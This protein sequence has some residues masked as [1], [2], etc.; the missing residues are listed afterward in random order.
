MWTN[1]SLVDAW[2]AAMFFGMVATVA[3][4]EAWKLTVAEMG[5]GERG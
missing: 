3:G 1:E 4:I 5:L 2:R